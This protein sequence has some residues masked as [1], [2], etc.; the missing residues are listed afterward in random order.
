MT[1]E[2]SSS[3][4]FVC[5]IEYGMLENQTLLMLKTFRE[6]AGRLQNS[7]ILAIKPRFGAKLNLETLKKLEDLSVELII[8]TKNNPYKWF[9]YANKIAAVTIAQSLAKTDLIAWLDSDIVIAKEP[10]ELIL[11]NDVDFAARCEILPPAVCNNESINIPYWQSLCSLLGTNFDALP[12]L[13]C[14]DRQIMVKMY[15][16]S[17][18]FVWRRA[19][20]FSQNYYQAFTKLIDS[21]L[22]QFD[23]NFFTADQVILGPIIISSGLRW[24]HLAHTSH[25]MTFQFQIDGAFASPNMK[26]SAIIHYSKSLMEPYKHKMIERLKDEVPKLHSD[27]QNELMSIDVVKFGVK[28]ILAKYLKFYRGLRWKLFAQNVNKVDKG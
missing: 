22:A 8:D 4:T 12:E 5:C 24:K 13:E 18:V 6:N 15:F 21:K 19:T 28:T 9:N 17:G 27:F 1:T 26:N 10:S 14:D 7:R 2:T 23:G 25:H 11:E 20:D 16:N 3:I